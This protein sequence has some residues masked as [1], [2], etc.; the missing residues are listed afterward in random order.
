M[1]N[2][3]DLNKFLKDTTKYEKAKS[4]LNMSWIWVVNNKTK[5]VSILLM[6][7]TACGVAIE[8]EML[9]KVLDTL[10]IWYSGE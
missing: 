2:N 6:V 3:Q 1:V 7:A 5:S 8:P 9:N 10:V 4:V